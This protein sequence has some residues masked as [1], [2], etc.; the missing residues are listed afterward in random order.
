VVTK[1][2]SLATDDILLLLADKFT[3]DLREIQDTSPI[4]SS[5][6]RINYYLYAYPKSRK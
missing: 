5:S 4:R 2:K 6:E 1:N 3:A